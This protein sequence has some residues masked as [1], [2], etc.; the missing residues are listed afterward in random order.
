MI[1][2]KFN[3]VL[4]KLSGESLKDS[5]SSQVLKPEILDYLSEQIE[6]IIKQN[7]QLAIVIGGGNT[8]IDIAVQSLNEQNAYRP[9]GV[10][11]GPFRVWGFMVEPDF[12]ERFNLLVRACEPRGIDRDGDGHGEA[13]KACKG[14]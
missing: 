7:I 11:S 9:S 6:L 12:V 13:R 2:R 5:S 3:R 1:V 10:R 8:A 4:L 14:E